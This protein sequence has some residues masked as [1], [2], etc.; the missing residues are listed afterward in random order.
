MGEIR[1]SEV[2]EDWLRAWITTAES[3]SRINLSNLKEQAIE[4]ANCVANASP[5]LTEH[6]EIII[7]DKCK[8]FPSELR[9]T[10]TAAC[11]EKESRIAVSKLILTQLG[12]EGIHFS[13][14]AEEID[15]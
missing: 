11:A 15:S 1:Q 2:E 10:Y 7:E 13:N 3:P 9:H 6:G 4:I 8:N 14:G 12:A 5:S